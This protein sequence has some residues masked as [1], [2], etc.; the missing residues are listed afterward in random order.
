M[1]QP[2]EELCLNESEH[3]KN[4]TAM[5]Y[6]VK[7]RAAPRGNRANPYLNRDWLYFHAAPRAA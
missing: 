2:G 1:H 3:R 5:P 6:G 4:Y 7:L